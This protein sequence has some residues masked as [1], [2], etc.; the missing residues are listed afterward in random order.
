MNEPDQKDQ[1]TAAAASAWGVGLNFAYGVIGFTMIG[2]ALQH[3]V[4]P[5]GAPW[6]ILGFALA[7]LLGGGYRFIRDAIAMGKASSEAAR[8][9]VNRP[10]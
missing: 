3:W 2:W 6:V 10:K 8:R 4:W 5:K 7:G 9:H 1:S